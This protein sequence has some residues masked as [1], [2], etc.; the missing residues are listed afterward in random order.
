M[1]CS[2]EPRRCLWIHT[3]QRSLSFISHLLFLSEGSFACH[4][5]LYPKCQCF[6]CKWCCAYLQEHFI[7]WASSPFSGYPLTGRTAIDFGCCFVNIKVTTRN[8]NFNLEHHAAAAK[9][10][11]SC[12]TL[13]DP[14]DCSQPASPSLGFSRQEHWSG[15]PFPSPMH[16]TE[17]WK[18]N[19]SVVSDS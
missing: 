7:T 1:L 6:K 3:P 2:A 19:C 17:K 11:Q 15:L 13:S 18:W 9:S 12:P 4:Q 10:L 5:I 16:E 8:V 14:I